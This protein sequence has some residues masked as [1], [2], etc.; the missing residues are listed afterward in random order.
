M[1]WKVIK[2]SGFILLGD[3]LSDLSGLAA[4]ICLIRYLGGASFGKYSF[5]IA[6]LYQFLIID[7]IWI[8]PILIRKVASENT[9]VSERLIGNSI[10]LKLLLSCVAVVLICGIVRYLNCSRDITK[11]V[12][13]SM[14]NIPLA[15]VISS[16]EVVFRTRLR[17]PYFVIFSFFSKLLYVVMVF[18]IILFRGRIEQF[19]LALIVS[20]MLNI[21]FIKCLLE[22]K[23]AEAYF[24]INYKL[25]FKL[26]NKILSESWP[27]FLTAIFIAAYSRLDHILL[28]K[29]KGPVE[30]GLYS[31]VVKLS[32]SFLIV[33]LAIAGSVFPLMAKYSV[34]CPESFKKIYSLTFKYL[35]ALFVPV[36][37]MVIFFSGYI[38][39][40]LFGAAFVS[41]G[42]ALNILIVAEIFASF[43][44]INNSILVAAGKQRF[45]P[46][47]TG[48]S[49]IV[50][51]A[52]NL[53]LIP[54]YGFIG[55]AIAALI[56]YGAGPVMGYMFFST[57]EYS[58]CMFNSTIKPLLASL[59]MMGVL[60][61]SAFTTK[62]LVVFAPISYIL[63]LYL[64]KGINKNDFCWADSLTI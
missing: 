28:F 41:S 25:D 10:I 63:T 15:V 44:I 59:V 13:L 34:V 38:I 61:L 57:R 40:I 52:L 42:T 3:V 58:R 22:N 11:L 62:V 32:E 1:L 8:K 53:F 19:M 18:I 14:C 4:G 48:V 37:I 29:I 46:V 36:V 47:F 16:Y 24:K 60:F 23:S 30:L 39:K 35:S 26:W 50:N 56:S 45:D 6:F 9:A 51:V 31:M 17:M 12:F 20:N 49:A 33:P 27:L 2:N 43:G 7:D 55:A 5:A 54:R 64:I 21:F